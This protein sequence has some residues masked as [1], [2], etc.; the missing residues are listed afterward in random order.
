MADDEQAVPAAEAVDEKVEDSKADVKADE[1]A[2]VKADE[3]ADEQA[4]PA[5]EAVDES[6]PDEKKA[7]AEVDDSK[8]DEKNGDEEEKKFKNPFDDRTPKPDPGDGLPTETPQEIE[9]KWDKDMLEKKACD[10]LHML[11]LLQCALELVRKRTIERNIY[12]KSIGRTDRFINQLDNPQIITNFINWHNK[13][14]EKNLFDGNL[15]ETGEKLHMINNII[16]EIGDVR[17]GPA[18]KIYTKLKKD[19]VIEKTTWMELPQPKMTL[20][21]WGKTKMYDAEKVLEECTVADTVALLEYGV[22]AAVVLANKDKA[23]RPAL[24]LVPDWQRK[25]CDYFKANEMTGE[26]IVNGKVKPMCQDIMDNLEKGNKK[27]RGGVNQVLRTMKT[28]YVH[29]ILEK[30]AK[31]KAASASANGDDKKSEE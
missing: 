19:V 28:C 21:T 2:D 24:E 22:L 29:E 14:K 23:K 4:L 27:L 30:A 12:F 11:Y 25:L 20:K 17:L 15:L 16:S 7:E 13:D 3:K 8:Q 18:T 5:A 6:K 1:K 31:A 9:F 10:T 26:K